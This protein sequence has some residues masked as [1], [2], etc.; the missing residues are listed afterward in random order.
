[1]IV[2]AG[3]AFAAVRIWMAPS[4]NPAERL[5]DSVVF[6]AEINV[7]PSLDQSP[8]LLN[9]L[10]K[11]DLLDGA[12]D[13]DEVIA[14]L[15]EKL[16]LEGIEASEFTDWMGTRGAAAVWV[17][18]LG[19]SH[20]VL[21]LASRN[22]GTAESSL[23]RILEASDEEFGYVVD[24]GLA[25]LVS[26]ESSPQEKAE[27]VV[28]RGRESPLAE[29]AAFQSDLATL[30]GEQQ[31]LLAWFDVAQVATMIDDSFG[32]DDVPADVDLADLDMFGSGT[33]IAGVR[34]TDDGLDVRYNSSGEAGLMTGRADWL[35]T[36]GALRNSHAAAM[37]TVPDDLSDFSA[38]VVEA[39][40]EHYNA[41]PDGLDEWLRGE[42]EYELAMTDQQF[43]EYESLLED[44]F[45]GRIDEGDEEFGRLVDLEDQYYFM[46]RQ[47]EFDDWLAD[48]GESKA[49]WR[50]EQALTHDEYLE[51]VVLYELTD[52]EIP[53]DFDDPYYQLA[54][55]FIRHGL[56]SDYS[57]YEPP[58][59][60]A[61]LVEEVIGLLSGATFTL[62][63]DSMFTEPQFGV[64]VE[65]ADASADRILELPIPDIDVLVGMLGDQ[66]T[67]EGSTLAFGEVA[68]GETSLAEHPLFDAAFDGAPE[69]ASVA[70]FVDVAAM[71]SDAHE[72]AEWLEPVSAFS[73]AHD[74]AN[75]T[76]LIRILI[77]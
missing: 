27:Q 60:G 59:D 47:Q 39:M 10:R 38:P 57:R 22:D 34:V 41:Q 53:F 2:L 29:S 51:L 64:A 32:F 19:R 66:L 69:V 62:A 44:W 67:M 12:H 9:L 16:D 37:L 35:D 33:A 42:W 13:I 23:A 58:L 49:Q 5:P 48:G 61:V 11:F 76:G 1:V 45:F 74:A 77:E 73:W 21:A 68:G 6:Y 43:A 54:T 15:V 46:G 20:I 26:G 36:L 7:D 52:G 17:D 50:F 56:V 3:G 63:F 28:D 4:V 55:R 30:G 31:L 70:L 40:E 18:D 75:G 25:V 65:F 71:N 72:P 14:T 8:N 24:D